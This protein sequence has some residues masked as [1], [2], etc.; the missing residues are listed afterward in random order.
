MIPVATKAWHWLW[1]PMPIGLPIGSLMIQR[2]ERTWYHVPRVLT[3]MLRIPGQS[4]S[5]DSHTDSCLITDSFQMTALLN[6]S[7]CSSCKTFLSKL[8]YLNIAGDWLNSWAHS[9][10]SIH[11]KITL[12][13]FVFKIANGSRRFLLCDHNCFAVQHLFFSNPLLAFARQRKSYSCIGTVPPRFVPASFVLIQFTIS[14]P[15]WT[16]QSFFST[17]ARCDSPGACDS[18]HCPKT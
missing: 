10:T 18:Q 14:L 11:V 3:W 13:A 2:P 15:F 16:I 4:W 9:V 6:M 8:K 5:N 7:P 12:T 17:Q 1:A